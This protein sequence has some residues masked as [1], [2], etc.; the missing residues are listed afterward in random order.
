MRE[1]LIAIQERIAAASKGRAVTLIAVSKF[2]PVEKIQ[3]AYAL[4]VRDFG[5]NYAQELLE[6]TAVVKDVRWHF[7]GRFQK[8]KINSLKEHVAAWHTVSSI[9]DVEALS[10]RVAS[11]A[12][13]LLQVNIGREPQKGG[14]LPE[15]VE[16]A[17]DRARALTHFRGL[18]CIPPVE[19]P[20]KWFDAMARLQERVRGDWLSMGMSDD[21]ELAIAHGATHVRIG[22]ALFGARPSLS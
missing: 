13:V 3:E 16:P 18:M 6:K 22:T 15:E 21:F 12:Q 7:I 8:N 19:T 1:R 9:E 11:P 2:Q 4:G 17:V 10:K 5:E 20:E 14:L